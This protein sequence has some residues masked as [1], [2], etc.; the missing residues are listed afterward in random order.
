[1]QLGE[2]SGLLIS[3]N[4]NQTKMNPKLILFSIE[5]KLVD[6]KRVRTYQRRNGD[7]V[8]VY[9]FAMHATP[10]SQHSD[11]IVKQQVSKEERAARVEMPI[12]G[13]GKVF[14]MG[15]RQAAAP[16]PQEPSQDDQVPF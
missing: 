1:M 2:P 4:Q 5:R 6:S 10:N 12:L 16:V 11:Y 13:N 14:D 15:E 8:E 3:T 7:T 9:D